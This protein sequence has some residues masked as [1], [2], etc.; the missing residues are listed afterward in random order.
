MPPKQPTVVYALGALHLLLASLG[1]LFCTYRTVTFFAGTSLGAR[2]LTPEQQQ[3]QTAFNHLLHTKAPGFTGYQVVANLAVPWLLT[4]LLLAA[5]IALLRRRRS[6][7][8]LSLAFALLS[9]L[10]KLGMAAYTLVFLLP[11]YQAPL[12][13]LDVSQPLNRFGVPMQDVA[14]T[15]EMTSILGA[16]AMPMLL[17]IYPFAVLL[18]TVR[19]DV[20][21]GFGRQNAPP[22]AAAPKAIP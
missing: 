14:A 12:H 15:A 5:G 19:R 21:E 13:A 7:R 20:R 3:R 6:G 9:I 1:V 10:H 11:I 22:A 17:L 2:W 8:T 4:L 18:V 16:V